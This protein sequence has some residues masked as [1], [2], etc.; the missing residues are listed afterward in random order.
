M[1]IFEQLQNISNTRDVDI[2]SMREKMDAIV[3]FFESK[4]DY[5]KQLGYFSNL[6]KIKVETLKQAN[7]FMVDP[8]A[9]ANELPED[10]R[11]DYLGMCRDNRYLYSGRF[12]FPV[13]D[14]KG[15]T[16]GWCGYDK[17][18]TPKY[19]DSHNIGY[20]AK[21][22]SLYGMEKMEE[23]YR[24]NEP[25]F[26]TEGIMC[27]LWLR[28]NSFNAL[29]LLGSYMTPYV[30]TILSRFKNRLIVIPDSDAAG[31]RLATQCKYKLPKARVVQSKV[32]KDVDDSRL[33]VDDLAN[34]LKSLTVCRF[35]KYF[36]DYSMISRKY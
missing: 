33:V 2:P 10:L 9:N 30:I 29:A 4:P 34:D 36:V 21:E 35:S 3:K 11:R 17:F 32:A 23:Y 8:D 1:N 20:T 12:V 5:E 16:M 28:E 22:S 15:H 13:K 6:R 24:S 31:N 26:V 7:S 14:V 18:E 19:L 27:T 25:I